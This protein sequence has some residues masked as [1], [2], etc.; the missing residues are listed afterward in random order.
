VLFA[1]AESL[2]CLLELF[3]VRRLQ[4]GGEPPLEDFYPG[5]DGQNDIVGHLRPPLAH[6]GVAAKQMAEGV[7]V[8]DEHEGRPHHSRLWPL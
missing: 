4:D 7:R 5:D 6:P 3:A 2:L 1:L 8:Q